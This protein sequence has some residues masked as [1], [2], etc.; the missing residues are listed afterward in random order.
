MKNG[1][2]EIFRTSLINT[3]GY[4]PE[5]FSE[6]YPCRR[7]IEEGYKLLKERL[8]LA[9]FSGKTAKTVKQDFHAK[10]DKPKRFVAYFKTPDSD[11]SIL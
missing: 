1:E 5:L 9:D 4:P 8:D 2:N 11:E 7:G 6:L 3:I 10:N